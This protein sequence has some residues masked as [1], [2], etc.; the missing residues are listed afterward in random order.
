MPGSLPG[1][2]KIFL[3]VTYKLCL[4][5][6]EFQQILNVLCFGSM[7]RQIWYD[8]WWSFA[9]Q[10]IESP[11]V[12]PYGKWIHPTAL[13]SVGQIKSSFISELV[14]CQA[15]CFMVWWQPTIHK[16]WV[17]SFLRNLKMLHSLK[18]SFAIPSPVNLW[19]NSWLSP[20]PL[21]LQAVGPMCLLML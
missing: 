11:G 21:R 5:L 10:R 7:V 18:L 16:S 4:Y 1:V 19:V 14:T 17:Y 2:W 13:L 12:W 15:N 6:E 20:C 8:C 9:K 3:F